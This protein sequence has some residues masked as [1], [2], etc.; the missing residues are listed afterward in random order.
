MES[1]VKFEISTATI[2]KVIGII[3]GIWLLYAIREVVVIFFIVLVI[4]FFLCP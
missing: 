2:L 1:K 4:L 3:L